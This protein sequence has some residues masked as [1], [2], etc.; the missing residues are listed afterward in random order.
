MIG[1]LIKVLS[2]FIKEFHDV[3]RQPRLMISL[4]GGPLLVLAAFGAT[5]RSANP[6]VTVVLVWPESGV[7]GI[8][9]EQAAQLI[10][11][12]FQ[13]IA[14]TSDKERAL[15]LL[16]LNQVDMVEVVPE[17][18][19]VAE[20]IGQR[21]EIQIFSKAIDPNKEAWIRAITYAQMNYINQQLL[22]QE[23]GLAQD[24]AREV[25]VELDTARGEFELIRANLKPEDITRVEKLVQS[26]RAVLINLIKYLPP[27]ATAFAS[28]APELG[29][30]QQNVNRLLDDLD[31]LEQV[32]HQ[33]N[34]AASVERLTDVVAEITNLQ[35]TIKIFIAIPAENII[36]P[37]Q[38][39]YTNLRG[40]P[41]SLV[42]FYAP[43]VLALLIQQLAVTL[44]SLGLVRERQM[45][46][47]EMFR[48]SP[49]RL[50][51]ILLGKSLAY[52]LYATI[53][54]II[55][56]ILLA[57]LNVPAPVNVLPY[58]LLLL[59]LAAASVGVGTLISALS[60]T[61]SQAI[62]LTMLVL[63]LSVFFTSFFLPITG[64]AWPAWIIA[65]LIPMTYAVDGLQSLMLMGASPS[66]IVW[67]GLIMLTLLSYGLVLLIMRRQYRK[68]LE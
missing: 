66:S 14:V 15:Q 30:V 24:K 47:F 40:S 19:P 51:Q 52:I 29:Q 43:A 21:P 35:G 23:A 25:S 11:S 12:N 65:L 56:T 27:E 53:A 36:S 32:L 44:A 42:V 54:G 7:P 18:K 22:A 49:L 48:A 17:I 50:S 28:L 55:L 64:F 45:G 38:E 26:L 58:L 60:R 2:F 8:S 68:V 57:L 62:Q 1:Y 34:L 4:V 13:L 41:F 37:V 10:N 61:D 9:Q 63:L 67:F 16:E 6:F 5:F 46:A 39:T 59:L 31:Q 33:G 3:R 20:N